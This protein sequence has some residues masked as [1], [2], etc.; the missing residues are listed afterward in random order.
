MRLRQ[1]P[2]LCASSTTGRG[3][4]GRPPWVGREVAQVDLAADDGLHARLHGVLRE[5]QRG[6]EGVR[7]R[8]R[9]RRHP[10]A[11]REGGQVMRRDRPFEERVLGMDAKVD[12]ARGHGRSI[13]RAGRESEAGRPSRRR[14]ALRESR[15]GRRRPR[16]QARGRRAATR[17]GPR[18]ATARGGDAT[19]GARRQGPTLAGGAGAALR[20]GALSALRPAALG[21]ARERLG[22]LDDAAKAF[23][24]R[25]SPRATGSRAAGRPPS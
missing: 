14:E 2:S 15:A 4:I 23:M 16:I 7:V 10:V 21:P 12:E 18:P 6:E 8:E 1:P 17:Q 20:C 19:P 22:M 24:T 5:L 13:G 11:G 25:A 9:H 3:R